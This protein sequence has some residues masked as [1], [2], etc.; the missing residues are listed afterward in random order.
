MKFFK[1]NF[2]K[3][4]DRPAWEFLEHKF[5]DLNRTF[6]PPPKKETLILYKD[7]IKLCRKFFW[8]NN[9]GK[10]W[11]DILQKTARKEIENNKLMIDSAEIGKTLVVARESL[12]EIEKKIFQVHLEMNKFIEETKNKN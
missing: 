12:I 11:A 8:N 10:Q 1:I 9:N 5:E 4:S 2:K 7:V 6:K 3:F